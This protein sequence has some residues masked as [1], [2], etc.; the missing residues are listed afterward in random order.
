MGTTT[1]TTLKNHDNIIDDTTIN[2]NNICVM[3]PSFFKEEK[4]DYSKNRN[5]DYEQI[6]LDIS[7]KLNIPIIYSINNFIEKQQK[8]SYNYTH[9]IRIIPY[10]FNNKNKKNSMNTTT[11]AIS[12]Q[13][14]LNNNTDKENKKNKTRIKHKK[15]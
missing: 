4:D 13:P 15:I 6:A 3:S 14:L 10:H 9:C 8:V 1:K 7:S 11:Y 12:I 5:Y 2:N